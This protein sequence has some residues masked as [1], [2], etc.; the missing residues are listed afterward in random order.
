MDCRAI[1]L[2]AL[3]LWAAVSWAVTVPTADG[4]VFLHP[5]AGYTITFP[6]GWD[7]LEHDGTHDVAGWCVIG[8]LRTSHTVGLTV[9]TLHTA[10]DSSLDS[11][12]QY[13]EST[14]PKLYTDF[15]LVNTATGS[16]C[17]LRATAVIFNGRLK[18]TTGL[19]QQYTAFI[20]KKDDSAFIIEYHTDTALTKTDAPLLRAVAMTF[21]FDTTKPARVDPPAPGR[22]SIPEQFTSVTLPDGWRAGVCEWS[23]PHKIGLLQRVRTHP[24][25]DFAAVALG[26]LTLP[27]GR[28]PAG[29]TQFVRERL[30]AE[31][32]SLTNVTV[33]TSTIGGH[34]APC[35]RGTTAFGGQAATCQAYYLA[36]NRRILL[37][38]CF[39]PRDAE[40]GNAKEFDAVLASVALQ[41]DPA[42]LPPP[43][44]RRTWS[45][46]GF[47]MIPPV[48]WGVT[49]ETWPKMP[50]KVI[51][52]TRQ[53]E[54]SGDHVYESLYVF[55]DPQ[56]TDM[57]PA[58]YAE[59]SKRSLADSLPNYKD[60]GEGDVTVNGYKAH[61]FM[62]SC[63][64]DGL[65]L[66]MLRYVIVDNKRAFVIN[67][68]A[69]PDT[70]A[71][72]KKA[73]D[74]CVESF[75]LVK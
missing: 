20:C 14:L 53:R 36:D 8:S 18:D 16:L 52:F 49:R 17:G 46:E 3:L 6:T 64:T 50:S 15:T 1:P 19:T 35:I 47:S 40:A 37:I 61:W 71:K 7:V 26:M 55:V 5:D 42:T 70:Y 41:V 56:D 65:T 43:P 33:G 63:T 72:Y 32:P 21:C 38:A 9:G 44:T 13:Y 30:T 45:V 22:V 23:D 66:G 58:D 75:K 69:L 11:V 28:T 73:F 57:A 39:S 60:L 34:P 67:T 62:Y 25:D 68:T 2:V 51:C 48:G 29:I 59:L 10:T 12:T 27:A 4:T 31:L 74:D 54:R 24:T